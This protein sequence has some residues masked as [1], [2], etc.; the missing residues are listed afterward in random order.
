MGMECASL[1]L[2][3]NPSLEVLAA[4]PSQAS[5]TILQ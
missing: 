5:K 4:Y 2:A 3:A 1:D